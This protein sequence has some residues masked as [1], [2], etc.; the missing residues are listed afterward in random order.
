ML[1]IPKSKKKLCGSPRTHNKHTNDVDDDTLRTLTRQALNSCI[2]LWVWRIYSQIFFSY[3][4]KFQ[5]ERIKSTDS[6]WDAQEK[7]IHAWRILKELSLQ[8]KKSP[9][10]EWIMSVSLPWYPY[11]RIITSVL[12]G[13]CGMMD[14][15]LDGYTSATTTLDAYWWWW[16]WWWEGENYFLQKKTY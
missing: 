7:K 13:Y 14:L 3:L 8:Y 1:G 15:F 9:C 10:T 6:T 12:C 11:R 5:V 4:L 16:L 2:V